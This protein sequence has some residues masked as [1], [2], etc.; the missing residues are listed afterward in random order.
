MLSGEGLAD[1]VRHPHPVS[2]TIGQ[3]VRQRRREADTELVRVRAGGHASRP[4]SHFPGAAHLLAEGTVTSR[5][6]PRMIHLCRTTQIL[7]RRLQGIAWTRRLCEDHEDQQQHPSPWTDHPFFLSSV[8][9]MSTLALIM[10]SATPAD[11]VPGSSPSAMK[12]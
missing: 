8:G 12:N 4:P 7:S 10:A 6:V 9:A 5:A 2:D 11:T 1:D 3:G